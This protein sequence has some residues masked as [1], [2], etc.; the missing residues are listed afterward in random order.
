MIYIK[1]AHASDSRSPI[2]NAPP[3]PKNIDEREILA[4]K[5]IKEMKLT[6]PTLVD[7]MED[8]AN[9]AYKAWPDRLFV[10]SKDMKVVW[11][12]K[13]GPWGFKPD[14]AKKALKEHLKK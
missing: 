4:S 2:P 5:C 9:K 14:E 1:E 7:S 6:I 12:A 10:I 8:Q 13:R 11:A 3:S